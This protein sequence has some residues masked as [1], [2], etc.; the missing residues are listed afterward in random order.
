MENFGTSWFIWYLSKFTES[1]P[2]IVGSFLIGPN[3]S[4]TF[5]VVKFDEEFKSFEILDVFEFFSLFSKWRFIVGDIA[6][7]AD[8][9]DKDDEDEG[10][11]EAKSSSE[12]FKSKKWFVFHFDFLL[13]FLSFLA[14]LI[15]QFG[16]LFHILIKTFNLLNSLPP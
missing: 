1:S 11:E 14:R 12:R 9:D 4:I 10:E 13:L 3:I 8:G 7:N 5:A 16:T 15:S 2:F 6:A